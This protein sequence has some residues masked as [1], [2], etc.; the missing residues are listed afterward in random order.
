MWRRYSCGHG[1]CASGDHCAA[2]CAMKTEFNTIGIISFLSHSF[3][4]PV[5]RQWQVR[6]PT[7][8]PVYYEAWYHLHACG[9]RYP[10]EE[11]LAQL[12]G[13]HKAY[14]KPYIW[15]TRTTRLWLLTPFF[16]FESFGIVY[17]MLDSYAVFLSYS[18]T[19]SAWLVKLEVQYSSVPQEPEDQEHNYTLCT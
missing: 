11:L 5:L 18:P 17:P 2:A 16:G 4:A 7:S 3:T 14:M 9:L 1:A 12:L 15:A 19:P 6:L 13:L 8:L 10:Q